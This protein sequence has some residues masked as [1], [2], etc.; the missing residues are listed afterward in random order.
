[1]VVLVVVVQQQQLGVVVAMGLVLLLAMAVQLLVVA[2]Q[3]MAQ[4]Q[5][6]QVGSC[7][8]VKG[9]ILSNCKHN[10]ADAAPTLLSCAGGGRG[11]LRSMQQ[12][13]QLTQL[14]WC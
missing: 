2:Q 9:C 13:M 1:M 6:A 10:A 5:V 4:Q 3:R 7:A 11:A 8:R 12:V 14:R